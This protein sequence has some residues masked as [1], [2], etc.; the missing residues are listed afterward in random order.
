MKAVECD[1]RDLCRDLACERLWSLWGSV[2]ELDSFSFEL[3]LAG[4]PQ[5]RPRLLYISSHGPTT[6]KD[7][8]ELVR[9]VARRA[10]VHVDGQRSGSQAAR[11]P[12]PCLSFDLSRLGNHYD[13]S[14]SSIVLDSRICSSLAGSPEASSSRG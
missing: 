3:T 11:R 7:I 14:T 4:D 6:T 9:G 12:C 10:P 1:V 8:L 2:G 5:R 13:D